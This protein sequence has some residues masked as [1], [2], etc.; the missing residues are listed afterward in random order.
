MI[1]DITIGQYYPANSKIH[2]LDPRVKIVGTL[3]YLI[4]LFTFKSIIG[5]VPQEDIIFENL[6]LRRMLHYT[7]D[8]KMPSDTSKAEKDKVFG[9]V[10]QEDLDQLS[11]DISSAEFMKSFQKGCQFCA[12]KDLCCQYY[13]F[14]K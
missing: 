9:S 13:K 10:T 4:S 8:L 3:L 2:S 5:Y 12:E 7:A 1:R 14:K 6:T 11:V